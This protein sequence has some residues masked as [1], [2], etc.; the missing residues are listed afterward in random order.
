MVNTVDEMFKDP[1][2]I[3][4]D[5]KPQDNWIGQMWN[6]VPTPVV[7]LNINNFNLKVQNGLQNSPQKQVK[8]DEFDAFGDFSIPSQ[9]NKHQ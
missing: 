7:S 1:F 2:R 6:S 5:Q 9:D 3:Q 8:S 4:K